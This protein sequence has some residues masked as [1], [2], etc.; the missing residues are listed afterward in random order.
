MANYSI[1]AVT[2]RVVYSGSAGAGPYAFAFEV[3][4]ANDLAVYKNT[5]LLTLTTDYTVSIGAAGTGSV[6][7]VSAAT[8]SDTITITG[9]RDIE[10]TTDF[11]TA[12]DLKAAALNEQLDSQII[13]I[14]QVSEANDRA[15]KAPVTD[16]TSIDMTLPAKA[17]RATKVLGFDANGDPVASTS[18]LTEIEANAVAAAVSAAAAATSASNAASSA[19][20]AA[21]SA[22]AASTSASNASTSETNAAASASSASSSASSASSSA[23]SASTSASNASTS[24]SNAATSESN[25]ATS[26]SNAATSESNAASS[27]S[28]AA[29][30]ASSAAASYDNF[31]DRYLG[32][33][34]SDPALDNDGD[35]LIT[36]ALYF[37][38]TAGSMKV[39]DGASWLDGYVSLGDA[40]LAANNLS[41]LDDAA[42]ARTNLGVTVTNISDQANSSTGWLDLPVG[43]TAQRGSPTSGA[44]RYNTDDSA[45]EGYNGSAWGALGG[46]NT[47]SNGLWENNATIS[48]DYTITSGNNALSAGPLTI[49]GGVTVTVPSGST[50]VVV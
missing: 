15:I 48:A 1:N 39:Y 35:A 30:S 17:T 3:L 13:M 25:A 2:R 31:D 42:T 23:S 37:N 22:S 11:V 20:G 38:T 9:A 14:Q 44:V 10:R 43:T 19:S 46:G 8:G 29:S 28:S 36:G 40:L 24:A 5:T 41:D 49:N 18:T 45:F 4:E 34:A 21:S 33:K 50:W 7:L 47:T 32:A 12:G 27:A 16:P 26:E 6:T